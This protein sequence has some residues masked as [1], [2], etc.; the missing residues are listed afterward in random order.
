MPV[1]ALSISTSQ[2]VDLSF[3]I[4][5]HGIGNLISGFTGGLQNYMVY[6]NSLL[7]LRS[8]GGSFSSEILLC[9]ASVALWVKGAD[10]AGYVPSV[11]IGA[12]IFHLGVDLMKESLYGKLF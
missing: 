11:V 4:V 10:I 5:G 3:E 8:G 1:P 7:F 6:S 2:D 12:L 9:I